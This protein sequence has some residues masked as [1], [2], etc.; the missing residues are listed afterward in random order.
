MGERDQ[1][2]CDARWWVSCH[3][4]SPGVLA[5]S[6]G[7]VVT[8][9][10]VPAAAVGGPLWAEG[11]GD[12]VICWEWERP[13]SQEVVFYC[14]L[15]PAAACCV[16]CRGYCWGCNLS[17][18]GPSFRHALS[19]PRPTGQS[20]EPRVSAQWISSVTRSQDGHHK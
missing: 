18:G 4:G 9:D 3:H 13:G 17:Y 10:V 20:Q 1:S 14:P 8:A 19:P 12:V 7:T 16:D 5:D 15:L 11:A 6:S 2:G